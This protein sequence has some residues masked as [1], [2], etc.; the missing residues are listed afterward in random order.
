LKAL[1]AIQLAETVAREHGIPTVPIFWVEAE[2]HDWNEV[3]SCTV[4]DTSLEPRGVGLAERRGDPTPIAQIV[5]DDSIRAVLDELA[6]ALPHTEFTADVLNDLGA[7][8]ASGAGMSD[9][10]ARWIERLLGSRG[11]IVFD[12]SDP[13]AKPLAAPV[14]A[15]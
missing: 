5:L 13:A 9:A 10:F 3:R 1:T 8:Y 2:D 7:A 15:R 4:F 6:A 14:F 11:L 12:A